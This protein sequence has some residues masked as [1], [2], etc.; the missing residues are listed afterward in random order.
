MSGE[1]VTPEQADEIIRRTDSFFTW[2]CGND[3]GRLAEIRRILRM[4]E[5]PTHGCK[6]EEFR[7]YWDASER[8]K[9]EWGLLRTEYI[10]NDYVASS[11]IGGANGFV[12]LDGVV[13]HTKNVGKYPSGEG[14]L[15]ELETIATAFP[16]L[17]AEAV[18]MNNEHCVEGLEPVI[19]YRIS[20][21]AVSVFDPD[22]GLWATVPPPQGEE[23]SVAQAMQRLVL[24]GFG[25]D[26]AF[27]M[28]HFKMWRARVDAAKVKS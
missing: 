12:Q 5:E 4:P 26:S 24:R 14:I 20:G 13:L 19:G 3:K 7:S 16:F 15:R 17:K 2:G 6:P 18:L 21:G 11:Y 1:P 9:E 27:D 22:E 23:P 10:H 25:D 28:D 8:F